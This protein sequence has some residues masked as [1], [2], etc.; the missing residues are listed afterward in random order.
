MFV[1]GQ[2]WS[3]V[4]AENPFYILKNLASLWCCPLKPSAWD[5]CIWLELSSGSG[6]SFPKQNCCIVSNTD[7]RFYVSWSRWAHNA[8]EILSH[9]SWCDELSL[10]Q[11]WWILSRKLISKYL[12]DCCSPAAWHTAVP[13]NCGFWNIRCFSSHSLSP[14]PTLWFFTGSWHHTHLICLLS[15]STEHKLLL[16]QKLLNSSSPTCTCCVECARY[17]IILNEN[18]Y[19]WMLFYI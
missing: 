6:C 11:E 15:V 10:E 1:D 4:R 14:S 19:E 17:W 2:P 13:S 18:M 3:T 7:L 9:S 12:D 5:S 8:E 16:E